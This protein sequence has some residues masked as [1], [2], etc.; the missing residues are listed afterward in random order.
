MPYL[1][2]KFEKFS[3]RIS[4]L[5]YKDRQG[6]YDSA[7]KDFLNNKLSKLEKTLDD[8]KLKTIVNLFHNGFPVVPFPVIERCLGMSVSS[9]S[10]KVT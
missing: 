9:A 3:P 8:E 4:Q 1:N 6:E 2:L 10:A 5:V 7:G